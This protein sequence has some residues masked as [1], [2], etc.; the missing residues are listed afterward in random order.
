MN[1]TAQQV[2]DL[3]EQHKTLF[4]AIEGDS[5]V[6]V[7]PKRGEWFVEFDWD[8]DHEGEMFAQDGDFVRY[9]GKDESATWEGDSWVT[10]EHDVVQPEHADDVRAPRL[11]MLRQAKVAV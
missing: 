9:E 8:Y 1:I 4:F 10:R 3:P 11:F 5:V 7:T 2:R 6:P